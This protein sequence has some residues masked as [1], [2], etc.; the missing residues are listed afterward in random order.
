MKPPEVLH[1]SLGPVAEGFSPPDC[2]EQRARIH[3]VAPGR[4]S[5][6]GFIHMKNSTLSEPRM[7]APLLRA[8]GFCTAPQGTSLPSTRTEPQ[9]PGCV[10]LRKNSLLCSTS[11]AC[12]EGKELWKRKRSSVLYGRIPA[13]PLPQ[14]SLATLGKL[15]ILRFSQVAT[16]YTLFIF[17]GA[18]C[19]TPPARCSEMQN[20]HCC[21]RSRRVWLASP[22]PRSR[23]PIWL[24]SAPSLGRALIIS[25]LS[26]L[27]FSLPCS[28][29]PHF[30]RGLL[31]CSAPLVF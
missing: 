5:T 10:P 19:K 17:P 25:V 18:L 11:G 13:T 21:N 27:S 6:T 29:P 16:N 8:M 4:A 15:F 23:V 14:P 22:V 26:A 31:P 28:S 30:L 9:A 2:V 1:R 24:P 12:V 20:A 7:A 3:P